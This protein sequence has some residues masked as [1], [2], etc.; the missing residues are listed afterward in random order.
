M[1]FKLLGQIGVYGEVLGTKSL[2]LE[3]FKKIFCCQYCHCLWR[4]PARG[5]QTDSCQDKYA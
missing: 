4:S 2:I 1:F 3:T 5:D